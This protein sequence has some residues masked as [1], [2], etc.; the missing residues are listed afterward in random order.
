MRALAAKVASRIITTWPALMLA[1]RRK[2]R[3]RGRAE[4]LDVSTST[5]KGFNQEGAP[6]GRSMAMNFIGREK[7][8]ERISLNHSVKP[9]EKVNRRWLVRLNTYGTRLIKLR[10]IRKIN[11]EETIDLQPVSWRAREEE[12]RGRI[13]WR[14]KKY[15]HERWEGPI[16]VVGRR[17]YRIREFISQNRVIGRGSMFEAIMGSNEVKMSENM[18]DLG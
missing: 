4:A 17:G 18:E 1:A 9:K 5:R 8:E 14:D 6:P 13:V 15:S 10:R 7:M 11:R 3:V 12:R 16:H 2:E